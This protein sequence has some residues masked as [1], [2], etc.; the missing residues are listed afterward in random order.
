MSY[1]ILQQ[2]GEYSLSS[3]VVDFIIESTENLIF[4]IVTGGATILEE[5]Y[6]PDA[7]DKIQIRELGLLFDNYLSAELD[8]TV[9]TQNSSDFAF[10]INNTL[11][12]TIH[13]LKCRAY[14]NL[15]VSSFF[16]G[17]SFLNAMKQ[18]KVTT[19]TAKEFLTCKL[20]HQVK[21]FVNYKVGNGFGTSDE[22]VLSSAITN[23]FTTLDVSF[24]V[25]AALFP[26][27]TPAD[28]VAIRVKLPEHIVV[29]LIDRANYLAPL[30]FKF[31]NS[32]DMPDTLITR[33]N[34]YRKGETM[35]E[36][37]RINRVDTKFNIVR[38]DSIEISSGK[39]FSMQD[40]D[41]FREMFES[42][43]VRIYFT[44]AWRKIIITDENSNVSLRGGR[45]E[46]ISFTF[47][48]ADTVDNRVITGD[49][50]I[51]WILEYG[52]WE[53][54]KVWLDEGQWN[55]LPS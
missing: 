39:I 51:N 55:D 32:F 35:S 47:K 20:S 48:F 18:T 36:T 30:N 44:G 12:S 41:R 50:F 38:N 29:L 13:V 37:A 26:N 53:G 43:D 33:G 46:P 24:E 2:P 23:A 31:K 10:Y 34:A 17:G 3:N 4:K 49:A 9:H 52:K 1:S 22:V 7:D 25:I 15:G 42:E 21:V 5:T 6:T 16:N 14:A 45:L 11:I 19:R 40:Y 8:D 27:I 28:I 54:D